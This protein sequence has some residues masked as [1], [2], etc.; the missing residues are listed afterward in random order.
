KPDKK[1]LKNAIDWALLHAKE[2]MSSFL[3]RLQKEN[4]Q[5][6]LRQN[7]QGLIYGITFID[8]HSKS[9]FN[10]SDL[11]NPYSAGGIQERLRINASTPLANKR[12]NLLEKPA[13]PEANKT[14]QNAEPK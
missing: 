10:G 11:G 12:V 8:H 3:S 13:R 9:V 14:G 4:V 7:D 1:R 6:V 2:G 5:A